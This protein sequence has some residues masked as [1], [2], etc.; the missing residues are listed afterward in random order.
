VQISS[1]PEGGKTLRFMKVL[2]IFGIGN[3]YITRRSSQL[4]Y[5]TDMEGHNTLW[6]P[7]NTTVMNSIQISYGFFVKYQCI[8]K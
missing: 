5:P 3:N 8:L 2:I 7:I 1:T 6:L 4:L